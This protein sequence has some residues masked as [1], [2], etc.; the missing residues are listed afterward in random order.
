[1]TSIDKAARDLAKAEERAEFLRAKIE[2]ERT[3][4]EALALLKHARALATRRDYVGAC[5]ESLD[6][7]KVLARLAQVQ[8]GDAQDGGE[9]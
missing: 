9:S 6:A 4:K 2:E 1:M 3:R 5:S 7:H 8:D